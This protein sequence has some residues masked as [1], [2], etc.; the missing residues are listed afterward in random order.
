METNIARKSDEKQ[1]GAKFVI[2]RVRGKTE[3]CK[4]A[5]KFDGSR[6]GGKSN[7][8]ERVLGERRKRRYN[9]RDSSREKDEAATTKSTRRPD[10]ET[11]RNGIGRE[12][13]RRAA[14]RTAASQRRRGRELH[15]CQ[16]RSGARLSE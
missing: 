16:S 7:C 1:G 14:A 3:I 12:P 15:T 2:I 6:F 13:T 4:M 11:G 9:I 5:S 10:H 8:C